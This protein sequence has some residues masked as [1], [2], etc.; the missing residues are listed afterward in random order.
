MRALIAL[1]AALNCAPARAG[2]VLTRIPAAPVPVLRGALSAPVLSA[3]AAPQL[4]GSLLAA[5]ALAP[6]LI[7]PQPSAAPAVQASPGIAVSAEAQPAAELF[8]QPAG[9]FSPAAG[10]SLENLLSFARNLEQLA[11]QDS[12]PA[13][14]AFWNGPQAR[15]A[16]VT[17]QGP[18]YLE[19]GAI[20]GR[21]NSSVLGG[22]RPH[23]RGNERGVDESE[24]QAERSGRAA[25]GASA[26]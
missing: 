1:L 13:L 15:S 3:P 7:A 5:P 6:S 19:E 12:R 4:G 16:E 24:S 26:R 22:Y 21:T 10:S 14:D 9:A 11:S 20:G 2:V 8:I 25:V 17:A 18:S 23:H